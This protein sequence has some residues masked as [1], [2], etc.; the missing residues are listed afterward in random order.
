MDQCLSRAYRSDDFDACL[1]IFDGNV[2]AF[3][4]KDERDEFGQ[5]LKDIEPERTPYIVL[6]LSDCVVACGGLSLDVSNGVASLSWGMVDRT[7]HRQGLGTRLIQERLKLARASPNVSRLVLA[8]SQHT[9]GFY[10]QHGFTV[11]KIM[12]DGFAPG[13]DRYDMTLQVAQ[14][15]D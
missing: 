11:S 8:T 2:P 6:T 1:S 13:L 9:A 4:S 14:R 10:R 15:A 12:P 3:F 7:V 5:F